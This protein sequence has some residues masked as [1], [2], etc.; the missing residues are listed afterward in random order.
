MSDR[1]SIGETSLPY[2]VIARQ[3]DLHFVKHRLNGVRLEAYDDCCQ[4]HD[5]GSS[6]ECGEW[7]VVSGWTRSQ[8]RDWL[9]Y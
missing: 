7:I 5:D 1:E 8:L 3:L 6:T 9:G 4:I 2:S